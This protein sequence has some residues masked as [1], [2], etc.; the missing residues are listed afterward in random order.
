MYKISFLLFLLN[1][2]R[3]LSLPIDSGNCFIGIN[4]TTSLQVTICS[5]IAIVIC[6]IGIFF[7]SLTAYILFSGKLSSRFFQ[8]LR[9]STFCSLVVNI[10]ILYIIIYLS[11]FTPTNFSDGNYLFSDFSLTYVFTYI[12]FPLWRVTYIFSS[13]H[14]ILLVYERIQF[15]KLNLKF[16][17]KV[18]IWKISLSILSFSILSSIPI[19]LT[20]Q[21]YE[22]KLAMND[23]QEAITLY[24]NIPSD[25]IKSPIFLYMVLI[26]ELGRDILQFCA[27]IIMDIS[28]IIIFRDYYTR[29]TILTKNSDSIRKKTQKNTLIAVIISFFSVLLHMEG[30]A[31]TLTA[32]NISHDLFTGNILMMVNIIGI[33]LKHSV[34]FFI[35]IKLNNQFRKKCPK[36]LSGW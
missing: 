28:L 26:I 2:H 31:V 11:I 36:F 23:T 21:I 5:I 29:R 6:S 20:H 3:N 16:L 17:S 32:K 22:S 9:V 14:D 15:L 34:N 13:L 24:T 30:F 27:E 25:F 35:L 33:T 4:D 1:H 19:S 18:P 8:C 12:S 10:N 7:N